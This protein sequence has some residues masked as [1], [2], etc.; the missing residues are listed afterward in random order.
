MGKTSLSVLAVACRCPMMKAMVITPGGPSGINRVP[1][2]AGPTDLRRRPGLDI[3]DRE[4]CAS[5]G[6]PARV[7][8][9]PP[10][11]SQPAFSVARRFCEL[12]ADGIEQQYRRGDA[13]DPLPAARSPASHSQSQIA[14]AGSTPMGLTGR[15]RVQASVSAYSPTTCHPVRARRLRAQPM[16]SSAKHPDRG[17]I[18]RRHLGR[19]PM[20]GDRK[21]VV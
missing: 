14:R 5:D 19:R 3:L 7:P 20:D 9:Y 6:D 8:A 18:L 4:W 2:S 17:H 12:R 15:R 13:A 21:S 10:T 11:C 1:V 16:T